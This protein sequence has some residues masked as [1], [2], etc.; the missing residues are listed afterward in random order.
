MT[1]DINDGLMLSAI[2]G[3]LRISQAE[4]HRMSGVP[5]PYISN[6]ETGKRVLDMKQLQAIQDS[7]GVSFDAVRPSFEQ[8]AAAVLTADGDGS[9]ADSAD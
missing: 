1:K 5:H 3:V 8:F 7:M 6:Y 9:E 4:L 2:R